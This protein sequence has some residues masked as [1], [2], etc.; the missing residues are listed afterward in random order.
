MNS[1][2]TL[3]IATNVIL[4]LW[5]VTR[6]CLSRQ[7]VE[8]NHVLAFTWGF[9]FYWILP[10]AIGA[11]RIFENMP[12]MSLWYQLFDDIGDS[13]LT[14]YLLISLL[15]YCA[16]VAGTE[17]GERHRFTKTKPG[18]DWNPNIGIMNGYL[19]IATACVLAAGI[20]VRGEFFTGYSKI[21][22]VEDLYNSGRPTFGATMSFSMALWILYASI[23]HRK[24]GQFAVRP[25]IFA[26]RFLLLY[27][28]AA[29]LATSMGSR[30]ILLSS[31]Y[32]VAAYCSVF[33][34]RWHWTTM[35][36]YAATLLAFALAVGTFR[37]SDGETYNVNVV[38]GGLTE[39][40]YGS[41]SLFYFL[42]KYSVGV[43]KWPVFLASDYIYLVP[44]IFLPMKDSLI[45]SPADRGIDIYDPVGGVNSF[46]SFMINFGALGTLLFFF[47]FFYGMG[48]LKSRKESI[49]SRTI[50]SMIS[51]WLLV[52]FFRNPFEVS[53]VKDIFQMSVIVPILVL[54]NVYL[55]SRSS[56][57]V[58]DETGIISTG[59]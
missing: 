11:W 9:L 54:G 43:L 31:V 5:Y 2:N 41:L 7:G 42:C 29:I 17:C 24:L 14:I 44:R 34:K 8:V 12:L 16:L 52:S 47:L 56:H 30:Y 49:L 50:Y 1:L 36:V 57:I 3:L 28:A 55:L 32:M 45:L 53:L 27:G 40:L 20:A 10:V 22:G 33:I 25:S 38:F 23:S 37:T 59:N 13:K 4:S 21:Q 15:V 6:K 18:S 51:G 19:L 35:S 48:V 46:L 39:T 26:N 58:G